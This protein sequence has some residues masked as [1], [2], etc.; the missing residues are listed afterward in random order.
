[1]ANHPKRPFANQPLAFA[2]RPLRHD[3]LLG[4]N[5][6]LTCRGGRRAV[7]LRKASLPPRSGAA[8]GSAAPHPH[9]APKNSQTSVALLELVTRQSKKAAR[10]LPGVFNPAAAACCRADFR[11]AES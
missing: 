8:P 6:K 5:I 11:K 10:R 2:Q 4:P 1:M 7:E 3:A 9:G